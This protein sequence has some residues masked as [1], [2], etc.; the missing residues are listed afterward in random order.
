MKKAKIIA[1]TLALT[2]ILTTSG[3]F[4][5]TGMYIGK[6][7]SAEG[8]T[9]VAR[10][11]DQGRGAYNKLFKVKPRVTKAGR[12][13][14]DT[15]NG[16]KVALPKTTY[17][18]TYVPDSY[19]L[20]DGEYPAS[21]TNEYGLVSVGTVSTGVKEAYE[22]LD[23]V[24]EPG[25]REAILAGLIACQ[26][27]TA[28]GA[29]DTLAKLIDKY[30]SEEYNTLFFVDKKEAWIFETYGGHT[31]AAMKMPTDK[32]SV[33]GNHIMID[34]VDPKDTENFVFSDKLFETIEKAGGAVKDDQGR[35]NL[36]KSIDNPSREDYNNMR[37]WIGMKTLAPSLVGEYSK[38]EFYP[39]FYTPD[40]KGSVTDLMQLY[41][42]R[43]EGTK[44]DMMK[45][46]NAGMRPIGVTRQSCVHI[47]QTYPN[48]PADSCNLQWLA[49]GNAEH[50]MF[51]PAFSGITD[52][53]A[54]YKP[55][56]NVFNENSVYF[57]CKRICSLAESD[58]AFLSQ[59]VKD[60]NLL[61]EKIMLN[62]MQNEIAKI[63]KAYAKSKANGRAY[64]TALGK[65]VAADQFKANKNLYR[66]LQFTQ[67]DNVN[68]RVNN[69]RKTT[70]VADSRLTQ[71]AKYY[72]YTVTKTV[73]K[74]GAKVYTIKNAAKTY[75]LTAGQ[76]AYTVTENGATTKAELSK[77]PYFF[78]GYLYAPM[79]FI[80]TL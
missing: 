10:S 49:L 9:V 59:G 70:F 60:Y 78:G 30:G 16:L 21:C 40:N 24:V 32:V 14:E 67:T 53:Y 58:R 27:K 33:F 71:A 44:Y 13:Y 66:K 1:L 48:L 28:R 55:D 41:G 34:W 68:D 2:M 23:P 64:V 77:A 73:K 65:K 38:D 43:Y 36:V 46:E 54:G 11:E 22:A 75:K 4:A 42:N 56:G 25:L 26:A 37:N 12:Y 29:V 17:K 72:G 35:Y 7:V 31:Y 79:D 63:N 3:A 69:A 15:A 39:L 8:T 18:Y 61:E 5:C 6:D 20:E 62:N 50:A 76:K 57:N 80:Q 19:D 52:T 74:D 45:S 51:I 47:L